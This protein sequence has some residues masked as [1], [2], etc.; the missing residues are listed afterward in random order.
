MKLIFKDLGKYDIFE[1]N[2]YDL[3]IELYRSGNVIIP[4]SGTAYC[5]DFDCKQMAASIGIT[6]EQLPITTMIERQE[7]PL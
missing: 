6:K 5:A 2:Q 7:N 1:S 4:F 3:L